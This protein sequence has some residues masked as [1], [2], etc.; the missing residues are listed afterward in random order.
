L[1]KRLRRG[2]AETTLSEGENFMDAQYHQHTAP[3]SIDTAIQECFV[4]RGN[5]YLGLW[6]GRQMG[7]AEASLVDY[8]QGVVAADYEEPGHEDVIRKLA[9][10]FRVKGLVVSR[11]EIK[12]QLCRMRAVAAWQFAMS[13]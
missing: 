9:R 13:D 12:R 3:Q 1:E 10:D 2:E 8:A 7:I 5:F 11:N 6:A 4:S